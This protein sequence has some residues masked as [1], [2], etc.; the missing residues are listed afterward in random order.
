MFLGERREDEVRLRDRR[1]AKWVCEPSGSPQIPP[2]PTAIN[3]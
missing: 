1:N 2:E 3:D